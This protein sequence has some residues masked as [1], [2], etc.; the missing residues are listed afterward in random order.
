M[1]GGRQQALS[2]ELGAFEIYQK[3]PGA[4]LW[5]NSVEG[6]KADQGEEK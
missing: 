3:G 2:R 1:V 6:K 5:G 4:L